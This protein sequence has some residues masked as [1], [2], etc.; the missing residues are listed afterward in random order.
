MSPTRE[1]LT[2]SLTNTLLESQMCDSIEEAGGVA[3]A[4]VSDTVVAETVE[5]D[6]QFQHCL[7]GVLREYLALSLE[8]ATSVVQ[9]ALVPFLD[10]DSTTSEN[11]N[12]QEYEKE[13]GQST[14]DEEDDGETIGEGDCELCE[15]FVQLTKHHLIPKSTWPRIEPKLLQAAAAMENS[16]IDRARRTLG[17]GLEHTLETLNDNVSTKSCVQRVLRRTCL[18]CR[19]CHS[20]V[21]ST[22]DNMTLALSYNTIDQ[23][24]SD[25]RIYKFCHW[26][27]RQKPGKYAVKL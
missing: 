7:V 24:L 14:S 3:D 8:E 26:A 2:K 20:A 21:H 10:D 17:Y 11:D 16:E 12:D 4:V 9:R 23:L 5:I 27:S 18:I 1:A 19:P 22:H 15:R 13:D 6:A 25:E